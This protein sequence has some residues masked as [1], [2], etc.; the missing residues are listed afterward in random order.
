V[1]LL[2]KSAALSLTFAKEKDADCRT[3]PQ[4]LKNFCR[5][6]SSPARDNKSSDCKCERQT[7][8]S[9]IVVLI[10]HQLGF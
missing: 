5:R 9:R 8:F 10:K 7:D 6:D 2:S 1:T 4:V 3:F